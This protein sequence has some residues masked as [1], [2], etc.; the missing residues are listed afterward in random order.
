MTNP[1]LTFEIM[2]ASQSLAEDIEREKAYLDADDASI[3]DE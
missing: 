2:D 3:P 1:V